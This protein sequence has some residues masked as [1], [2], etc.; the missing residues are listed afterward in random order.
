MQ[1]YVKTQREEFKKYIIKNHLKIIFNHLKI[2]IC[3]IVVY[4]ELSYYNAKNLR[5]HDIQELNG[6]LDNLENYLNKYREEYDVLGDTQMFIN[7]MILALKVTT[8]LMVKEDENEYKNKHILGNII[9][10]SGK[11]QNKEK[12]W[13]TNEFMEN[14]KL[15]SG[16]DD[17]KLKIDIF[18]DNMEK[19]KELKSEGFVPY[20]HDE[21]WKKYV[22]LPEY[23]DMID[24]YYDKKRKGSEKI[25]GD[26]VLLLE[27]EIKQLVKDIRA[28]VDKMKIQSDKYYAEDSYI[29]NFVSKVL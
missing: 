15:A 14:F 6:S 7:K 19:L 16:F 3:L 8:K 24:Q 10:N 27:M 2:I 26:E 20:D 18:K 11:K 4:N 1:T 28:Y 29:F 12:K 23:V 13:K 17:L 25:K 9:L 21:K 22:F 5:E